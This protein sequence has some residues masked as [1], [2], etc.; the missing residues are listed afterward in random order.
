VARFLTVL[1]AR[2]HARAVTTHDREDDR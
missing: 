1:H 2:R